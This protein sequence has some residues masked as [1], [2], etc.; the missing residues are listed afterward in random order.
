MARL[1]PRPWPSAAGPGRPPPA[2]AVRRR[3]V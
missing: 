2:L 1:R 3:P